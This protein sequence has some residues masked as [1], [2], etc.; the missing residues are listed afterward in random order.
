MLLSK[1]NLL[2]HISNTMRTPEKPAFGPKQRD[3]YNLRSSRSPVGASPDTKSPQFAHRKDYG[4]GNTPLPPDPRGEREQSQI[5][6]DEDDNEDYPHQEEG[7]S[8]RFTSEVMSGPETAPKKKL[9]KPEIKTESSSRKFY[10]FGA[11]VMLLSVYAY[12][13]RCPE[14]QAHHETYKTCKFQ[15][16]QQEYSGQDK[17]LWLALETGLENIINKQTYAPA[18]Y[19]F[20]YKRNPTKEVV[21]INKIANKASECFGKLHYLI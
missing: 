15:R 3:N 21:L 8:G 14:F 6:S 4:N 16:L 13:R 18:V 7:H 1:R 19:L 5:S 10:I 12:A 20:I 17:L 9:T 11:I 2:S